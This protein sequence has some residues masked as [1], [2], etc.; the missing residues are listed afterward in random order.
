[1]DWTVIGA[2]AIGGLAIIITNIYGWYKLLGKKIDFGDYK[3]YITLNFLVLFGTILTYIGIPYLK[4][5]LMIILLLCGNYYLVSKQLSICITSVFLVQLITMLSEVVV[6]LVASL[7]MGNYLE[8]LMK[9]PLGIILCNICIAL[10]LFVLLNSKTACKLYNHLIK[11][12][13]NLKKNNLIIC[14]IAT[15]I[16]AI[17]FM[18]LGYMQLPQIVITIINSILVVIYVSFVI[19]LINSYDKYRKINGKYE[20]SL[21]SLREYENIMDQYRVNNH[22]NKNQLLT[23]R[24]MVKAKDKTTVNYIDKLVDN[25]IKDNENIFYK[26]S[27]IPEGGLRATIY[28]KLCKMKD[29]NIDYTLEIANNV[30]AVDLIKM[31]DETML[32]ICKIVGVFL[33]NAIEAVE[34]LDEKD[35]IVEIFTIDNNLCIQISNNYD[36]EIV[37][38]KI[39]HKGYTTKG[40]GHGYG[41]SLVEQLVELDSNLINEKEISKDIFT[42]R[43]KIK[44]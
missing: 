30:R 9:E 33:D 14:C 4:L 35:I 27:K 31:G 19:G 24:N 6:T 15:I 43:L 40:K 42:Q 1:M 44:M 28:S 18:I 3:I 12:L 37:L 23:I 17:T 7:F 36:E 26:T 41:L 34:N 5:V 39:S 13:G 11:L 8:I 25:K 10:L 29:T 20:T 22:E 2:F 32:N 16:L 38:D 21:S